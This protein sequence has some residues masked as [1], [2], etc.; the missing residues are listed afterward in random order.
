MASA[1]VLVLLP[2]ST[3]GP[4]RCAA[5]RDLRGGVPQLRP[6][7]P[8]TASAQDFPH[9]PHYLLAAGGGGSVGGEAP[10]RTRGPR[11]PGSGQGLGVGEF[12]LTVVFLSWVLTSSPSTCVLL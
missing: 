6:P 7:L 10:V 4:S 2:F 1:L 5:G 12:P 9:R 11:V 8:C 3:V